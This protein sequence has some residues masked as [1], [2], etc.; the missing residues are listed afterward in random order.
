M[1]SVDNE[2]FSIAKIEGNIRYIQYMSTLYGCPRF[3][4]P[5]TVGSG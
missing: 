4:I 1:K 5:T 2:M 3:N